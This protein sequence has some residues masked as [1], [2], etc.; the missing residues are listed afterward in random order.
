MYDHVPCHVPCHVQTI[1][2]SCSLMFI[3][4]HRM[5]RYLEGLLVTVD[6]LHIHVL[7]LQDCPTEEWE[8]K[9]I[10]PINQRHQ[11]QRSGIHRRFFWWENSHDFADHWD[12]LSHVFKIH[13]FW[14][15][16]AGNLATRP[17]HFLEL[18]YAI[19]LDIALSTKNHVVF[20]KKDALLGGELPTDRKWVITLV[21]SGRLAPTK[22]PLK[23]PGWT[24][25]PKRS[26]GWIT[27]K[28]LRALRSPGSYAHH[29]QENLPG[30]RPP[31]LT[32]VQAIPHSSH[33]KFIWRFP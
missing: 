24:H 32:S 25:P 20:T 26:V 18:S 13:V 29:L 4:V 7:F 14:V 12:A 27:T 11:I 21:I 1:V 9:R 30:R 23:S 5:F 22:I 6:K 16:C 8:T 28:W 10:G 3:D 15:R 33:P 17:T 31:P 19:F 2:W